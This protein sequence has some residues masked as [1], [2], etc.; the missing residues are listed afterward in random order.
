MRGGWFGG[1]LE[2]LWVPAVW[3]AA[4]PVSAR[5]VAGWGMGKEAVWHGQARIKGRLEV[6]HILI[7]EGRSN[8]KASAMSAVQHCSKKRSMQGGALDT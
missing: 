8:A 4:G 5:R 1:V 6:V 7:A 2:K 3:P